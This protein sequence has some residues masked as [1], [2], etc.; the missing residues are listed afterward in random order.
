MEHRKSCCW[1][2]GRALVSRQLSGSAKAKLYSTEAEKVPLYFLSLMQNHND[3]KLHS[4]L[5]TW[6]KSLN[7]ILFFLEINY[8]GIFVIVF[9]TEL[10]L[11]HSPFHSLF[12]LFS[13]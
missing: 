3:L 7:S 2:V 4:K 12:L 13:P 10:S 1:A 11:Y 9:V 5:K 6:K 8:L